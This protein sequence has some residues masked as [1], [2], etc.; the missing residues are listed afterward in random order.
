MHG[1]ITSQTGCAIGAA[2]TG[3]VAGWAVHK[4]KIV[5]IVLVTQ[6]LTTTDGSFLGQIASDAGIG[7]G[8]GETG[9]TTC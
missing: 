6:T 5:V 4:G 2:R 1:C 3:V 7:V 8:T 9:I